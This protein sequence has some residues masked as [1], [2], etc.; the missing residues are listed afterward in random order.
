MGVTELSSDPERIHAVMMTIEGLVL[1]DALFDGKLTI[2]RGVAPFDSREFAEGLMDDIR[3]IFFKPAGN[4]VDAGLTEDGF[5]GVPLPGFKGWGCGRD[6]PFKRQNG[7]SKIRKRSGWFARLR[8][9]S[10]PCVPPKG[11]PLPLTE[12]AGYQLKSATDQCGTHNRL[13]GHC[14]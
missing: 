8:I 10:N 12:P 6:G 7:N 2:N 14:Q 9:Q 3:L 4:A 13:T 5:P 1:F 11:S